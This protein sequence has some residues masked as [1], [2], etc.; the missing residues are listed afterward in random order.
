MSYRFAPYPPNHDPVQEGRER[1]AIEEIHASL[2]RADWFAQEV[3]EHGIGWWQVQRLAQVADQATALATE[4][5][6]LAREQMLANATPEQLDA[7]RKYMKP[8]DEE[9]AGGA[10]A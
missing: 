1:A 10:A 8:E 4:L 3:K 6:D 7:L 2:L 5:G 9:D